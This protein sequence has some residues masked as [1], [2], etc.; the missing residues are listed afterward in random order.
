MRVR[1]PRPSGLPWFGKV[2]IWKV[3][4]QR[5]LVSA[6]WRAAR[7]PT[8]GSVRRHSPRSRSVIAFAQTS[9]WLGEKLVAGRNLRQMQMRQCI[10]TFV[11][12]TQDVVQRR[13]L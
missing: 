11:R 6:P 4:V 5:D 8:P 13:Q 9:P 7:E 3:L 2:L 1:L 10:D 12:A